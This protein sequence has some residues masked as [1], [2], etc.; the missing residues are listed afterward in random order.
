MDLNE[1]DVCD[2]E[3]D[4]HEHEDVEQEE[5]NVE[6]SDRE[7]ETLMA[8]HLASVTK[9][10]PVMPP[11]KGKINLICIA[12]KWLNDPGSSP[13]SVGSS[14]RFTEQIYK[15][16]SGG[17]IDF[18]VISKQVDVPYNKAAKNI[19]KAE[20]FAK[21]KVPPPNKDRTIYVIVNHGAK[22]YSNA[23]GNTAHLYGT[24]KRDF[25]H[26]VGHLRPFSLGHSGAYINGKL[27]AYR[28]GTSFM[29][30]FSST[31]LT[32]AQLYLLGWLPQ[33]KVGLFEED[34]APTD[35]DICPLYAKND[36]PG[37]KVVVIPRGD[38]RPLY[39]SMP[40]VQ[41]KNV[42][43]LHLSSGRGTQRVAVFGNRAEYGD[44]IF[45]K[46]TGSAADHASRGLTGE[47][48][49]TVRVSVAAKD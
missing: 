1:L 4:L 41:G 26:E 42:L 31:R 27:E 10:A 22:G 35:F 25:L 12:L 15:E 48:F 34:D 28:D 5:S 13:A 45:E 17:L 32:G 30:R 24:L 43:M 47:D 19:N 18:N 14:G 8:V 36:K 37:M 7:S 33:N 29:G 46:I 49:V 40:N 2:C 20:K 38:L 39:L 23:G 9:L 6:L 16:L 44:Y 21:A 3:L 11:V